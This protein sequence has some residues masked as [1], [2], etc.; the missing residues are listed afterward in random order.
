MV[1]R[2]I[3]EIHVSADGIDGIGVGEVGDTGCHHTG[4]GLA[5]GLGA[6]FQGPGIHNR[7]VGTEKGGSYRSG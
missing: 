5:A 6:F 2:T 4:P 1:N 7:I 3:V